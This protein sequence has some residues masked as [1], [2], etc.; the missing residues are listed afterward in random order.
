MDPQKWDVCPTHRPTCLLNPD[1]LAL[2]IPTL[3]PRYP[4]KL[5]KTS[6]DLFA[7]IWKTFDSVLHDL[8]LQ[9]NLHFILGIDHGCHDRRRA[10]PT[11]GKRRI[12]GEICWTVPG[13]PVPAWDDSRDLGQ[14]RILSHRCDVRH[15]LFR[16]NEKVRD[17][18]WIP[19][20]VVKVTQSRLF[21]KKQN[22]SPVGLWPNPGFIKNSQNLKISVSFCCTRYRNLKRI[23]WSQG[24]WRTLT[25]IDTCSLW[26]ESRM[27]WFT[28][29]QTWVLFLWSEDP[30]VCNII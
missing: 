14:R 3:W 19:S 5:F 22:E 2:F 7:K 23:F 9:K 8:I 25:K 18:H 16:V 12:A 26:T 4:P 21:G 10:D 29:D 15:C 30:D 20:S 6:T 27:S 24:T 1:P 13:L 28:M 11:R 17:Q